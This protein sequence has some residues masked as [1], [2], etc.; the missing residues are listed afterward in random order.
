[1]GGRDPVF[2]GEAW[3]RHE[4]VLTRPFFLARTEVTVAAFAEF[5]AATG[6]RTTAEVAAA[7]G[8]DSVAGADPVVN[9]PASVAPTWR[10]PG[11]LQ[12]ARW[13]VTVV[14]F[15][16]AV[17]YANWRS[18]QDGL[19]PAY[20]FVRGMV[21]WD[22]QADGW[23]LPTEAEWEY[24]ARC[25]GVCEA[26][27]GDDPWDLGPV[28]RARPNELGLAGLHDAVL[29]WCWDGYQPYPDARRVDPV[30]ADPEG[31]RVVRGGSVTAREW[32]AEIYHTDVLGFRLAR[33]APSPPESAGDADA[34]VARDPLTGASVGELRTWQRQLA[35]TVR[36]QHAEASLADSLAAA[37]RRSREGLQAA[38]GVLAGLG[39]LSLVLGAAV[40]SSSATEPTE[41]AQPEPDAVHTG[42]AMVIAGAVV[43]VV[44]AA[45]SLVARHDAELPPEE[46]L[47][48]ARAILRQRQLAGGA[49][50]VGV[51]LRF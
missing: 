31:R 37:H 19:M 14:S 41:P 15:R 32:A 20:R 50:A 6:Y 30:A 47:R 29:E 42:Q 23:R 24:A 26:P 1:M 38:G 17:R 25:G 28:G 4:V 16:D 39:T 22:R 27:A 12:G 11:R 36:R 44:G 45:I 48:R 8:P 18:R 9:G 46:A 43:A 7:A 5:G 10:R 13:P 3:P 35:R 2:G 51:T 21:V 40:A 33:R 34:A 49:S